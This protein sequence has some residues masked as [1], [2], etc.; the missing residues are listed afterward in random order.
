MRRHGGLASAAAIVLA[1][2]VGCSA[3][4]TVESVESEESTDQPSTAATSGPPTPEPPT[5]RQVKKIIVAPVR[6]EYTLETSDGAEL[7]SMA[8]IAHPRAREWT[9]TLELDDPST[10]GAADLRATVRSIGKQLW[11]QFDAWSHSPLNG[12]WADVSAGAPA[13]G[14]FAPSIGIPGPV[15]VLASLHTSNESAPLPKTPFGA[16]LP[17]RSAVANALSPRL[18]AALDLDEVSPGTVAAQVQVRRQDDV[19]IDIRG[20]D[21]S[22]SVTGLGGTVPAKIDP[23]LRAMHIGMRVWPSVNPP[24]ILPPAQDL[25]MTPTDVGEDGDYAGCPGAKEPEQELHQS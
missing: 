18:A 14:N 12:C 22:D 6:F 23:L 2:V 11:L 25:V 19:A 8:G 17:L 1:L 24:K 21:I 7:F 4:P 13:L 10:P 15:L 9:G 20:L 5:L 16:S 3:E